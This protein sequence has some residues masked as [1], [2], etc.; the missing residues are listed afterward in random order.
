V[1]SYPQSPQV[2]V[3]GQQS[4]LDLSTIHD[5]AHYVF[6]EAWNGTLAVVL[7]A[8]DEHDRGFQT[9]TA[10]Q[11]EATTK[12]D[13][14]WYTKTTPGNVLVMPS[15][16]CATVVGWQP[17]TK[18]LCLVH[19]GR[20]ALTPHGTCQCQTILSR[21][22]NVFGYRACQTVDDVLFTVTPCISAAQFPHDFHATA[23]ALIDPFRELHRMC[24]KYQT[25]SD[26]GR[27]ALDLRAMIRLQLEQWY[28]VPRKNIR[29]HEA[30]T[31]THKAL[32][33]RRGGDQSHNLTMVLF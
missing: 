4:E 31:Y 14:V 28:Q 25:V 13:G 21:L 15:A 23:R 19:G 12:A 29:T 11:W 27:D 16:D 9:I 3:L 18:R 2:V 1:H 10:A 6:G 17:N 30:C 5:R 22:V 26:D 32:A 24:P 8:R 33:S 7:P 20:P